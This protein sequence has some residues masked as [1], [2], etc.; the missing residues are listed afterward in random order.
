MGCVLSVQIKGIT[1]KLL[2]S[3]KTNSIFFQ[4][5]AVKQMGAVVVTK[6][7]EP[8]TH[9]AVVV[10]VSSPLA[11]IRSSSVLIASLTACTQ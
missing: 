10:I 2:T 1:C 11:L 3:P 9:G 8:I 4:R 7:D 5:G 6:R